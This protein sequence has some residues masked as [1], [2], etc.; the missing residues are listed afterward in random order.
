VSWRACN[1]E[2]RASLVSTL[3]FATRYGTLLRVGI[4]GTVTASLVAAVL[5]DQ[6]WLGGF[7]VSD[8]GALFR[9][10][11]ALT[12]LP[13]GW[14]NPR[15]GERPGG[16]PVLV[17]AADPGRARTA[18]ADSHPDAGRSESAAPSRG[19]VGPADRLEAPFPLHLA[20]LIGVNEV[21]WLFRLVGLLW[22]AQAA[23]HIVESVSRA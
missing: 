15:L 8:A 4:L 6:G 14:L 20:A 16:A 12:V 2:H 22:L 10:G 9:L 3:G 13:L 5:I 21:L 23:F 7:R 11:V 1:D 18:S 17:R 19:G